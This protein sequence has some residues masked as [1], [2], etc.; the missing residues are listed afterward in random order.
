MCFENQL[1]IEVE[2]R[3]A[4]PRPPETFLPAKRQN[5]TNEF[6]ENPCAATNFFGWF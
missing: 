3:E 1:S 6:K 5:P 2:T 4:G